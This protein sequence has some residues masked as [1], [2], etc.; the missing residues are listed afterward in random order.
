M[1]DYS[2][3]KF[4][5]LFA[6]ELGFESAALDRDIAFTDDLGLDSLSLVNFIIKVERRYSIKFNMNSLWGLKTLGET[7]DYFVSE[8]TGGNQ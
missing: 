1:E 8:L 6:D 7:Y 5:D 2:F 3:D 4:K